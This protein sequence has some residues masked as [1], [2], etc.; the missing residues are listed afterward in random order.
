MHSG[1]VI[2]EHSNRRNHSLPHDPVRSSRPDAFKAACPE[3]A[4][5]F[6]SVVINPANGFSGAKLQMSAMPA[7]KPNV[8]HLTFLKQTL[9][10]QLA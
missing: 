4:A 7:V 1:A 2:H 10:R 5:R 3:C 6:G 9:R 8:S